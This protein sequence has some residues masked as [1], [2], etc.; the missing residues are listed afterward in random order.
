[1]GPAR[2]ER[3]NGLSRRPVNR[4]DR[5]LHNVG[6]TGWELAEL[7]CGAAKVLCQQLWFEPA[8]Q[9][10]Q[11]ERAMFAIQAVV[12][13]QDR[14][15]GLGSQCL[16]GM[17]M[18]FREIPKIARSVIDNLKLSVWVQHGNLAPT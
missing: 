16:D 14:V 10:S 13:R 5:A 7:A 2:G 1:M 18:P 12:E 6:F 17:A 3:L 15:A 9:V 8:D 11:T 4:N